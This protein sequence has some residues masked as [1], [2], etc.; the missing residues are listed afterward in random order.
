MGKAMGS[1]MK[2]AG[3][4][5]SYQVLSEKVWRNRTSLNR[6]LGKDRLALGFSIVSSQEAIDCFIDQSFMGFISNLPY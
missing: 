2:K 3:F 5:T 6:D 1:S 4:V